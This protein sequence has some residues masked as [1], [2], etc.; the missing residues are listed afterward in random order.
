MKWYDMMK[1]FELKWYDMN[2]YGLKR[3]EL[4]SKCQANNGAETQALDKAIVEAQEM[5]NATSLGTTGAYCT[6][7]EQ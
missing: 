6:Q 5:S 2:W 7:G 1:W 4:I 3:H